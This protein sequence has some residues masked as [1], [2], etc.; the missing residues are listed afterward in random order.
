MMKLSSKL[1]YLACLF[2]SSFVRGNTYVN[3]TTF[4]GDIIPT[5]SSISAAYGTALANKLVEKGL[6]EVPD[7]RG[8]PTSINL[9]RQN[10]DADLEMWEVLVY[11]QMNDYN[12]T[13]LKTVKKNLRKFQKK[14]G[15]IKFTWLNETPTDN[16]PFLN[17]GTFGNDICSSYVGVDKTAYTSDGQFL[18]IGLSCLSEGEIHHELLHALGLFHEHSRPDRDSYVTVRDEWIQ[19]GEEVNFEIASLLDT[20]DTKYDYESVMHYGEYQFTT[21]TT[22]KTIN[23]R[24]NEVGQRDGISKGDNVVTRLL[25]QCFTGPRTLT[26]YKQNGGKNRCNTDCKCGLRKKGCE[27]PT[28]TDDSTWCKGSLVCKNNR[29]VKDRK[30]VV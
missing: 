2:L 1:F 6:V 22:Q 16:S 24:G 19:E 26:A 9:W 25:Y 8:S 21:D 29:C 11:F 7:A 23:A 3:V 4:E 12:S 20:L 5:Y 27:L 15:V 30:S 28:G 18:F 17:I 10:W 13:E 14:S